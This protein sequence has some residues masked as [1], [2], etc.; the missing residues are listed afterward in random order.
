[1][2]RRAGGEPRDQR[3]RHVRGEKAEAKKAHHNLQQSQCS[4]PISQ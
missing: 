4:T 3:V 1:V 2:T